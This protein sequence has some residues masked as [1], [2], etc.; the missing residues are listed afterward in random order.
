MASVIAATELALAESRARPCSSQT[1]RVRCPD[2]PDESEFEPL[3]SLED[4][5][6]ES[7]AKF[8]RKEIYYT[9]RRLRPPDRLRDFTPVAQYF[10]VACY[11][12]IVLIVLLKLALR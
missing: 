7:P 3:V 12:I 11:L 2:E 5:E 8:R 4:L 9:G 10:L 1:I 6:I